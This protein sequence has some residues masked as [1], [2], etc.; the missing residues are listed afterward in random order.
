MFMTTTAYP[1]DLGRF[2]KHHAFFLLLSKM[3]AYPAWEGLIEQYKDTSPKEAKFVEKLFRRCL[4]TKGDHHSYRVLIYGAAH[5]AQQ[6]LDLVAFSDKSVVEALILDLKPEGFLPTPKFTGYHPS[7]THWIAA[8]E[9][10][11]ALEVDDN[12]KTNALE[13]LARTYSRCLQQT[14]IEDIRTTIVGEIVL[15]TGSLGTFLEEGSHGN[16]ETEAQHALRE[17]LTDEQL[18][19]LVADLVAQ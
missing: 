18:V 8:K 15:F 13:L 11:K 17:L 4:K 9:S 10:I 2:P 14:T 7:H 6:K 1:H 3:S 5:M 12:E 19:S 16:P